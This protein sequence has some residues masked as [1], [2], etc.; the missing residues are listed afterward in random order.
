MLDPIKQSENAIVNILLTFVYTGTEFNGIIWLGKTFVID[1]AED[2]V[3][4]LRSEDF[5]ACD[6]D[7]IGGKIITD[8]TE[9]W[10]EIF[11]L[12]QIFALEHTNIFQTFTVAWDIWN[13]AELNFVVFDY[14]MKI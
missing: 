2:K 12:A 11:G 8:C 5:I 1:F 13:F 10:L 9:C 6:A 3:D 4:Q 7:G 14:F